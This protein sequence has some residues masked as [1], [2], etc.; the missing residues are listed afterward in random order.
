M[1]K[2]SECIHFGA[3]LSKESTT[4]FILF[5]F[6]KF[7]LNVVTSKEGMCKTSYFYC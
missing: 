6:L 3:D 2:M 1:L 4:H 5:E 7:L